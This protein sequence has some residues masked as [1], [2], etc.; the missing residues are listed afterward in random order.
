MSTIRKLSSLCRPQ[1]ILREDTHLV[2]VLPNSFYHFNAD[3]A[4]KL[5]SP[6]GGHDTEIHQV[7]AHPVTDRERCGSV[8]VDLVGMRGM[9]DPVLADEFPDVIGLLDRERDRVD[10]CAGDRTCDAQGEG[11]PARADF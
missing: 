3:N 6:L 4:V 7:H 2:H 1:P 5:A 10:G 9:R 11:A 8:A